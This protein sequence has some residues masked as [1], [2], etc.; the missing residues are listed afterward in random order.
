MLHSSPLRVRRQYSIEMHATPRQL[1][2]LCGSKTLHR[3]SHVVIIV[4]VVA[5]AAVV[6]GYLVA[7]PR[8]LRGLGI[9]EIKVLWEFVVWCEIGEMKLLS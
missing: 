8:L 6:A 4:V 2:W 1:L 5:A 3:I 9:T 7:S